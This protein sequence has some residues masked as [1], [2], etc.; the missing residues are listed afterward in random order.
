MDEMKAEILKYTKEQ[1]K[2]FKEVEIPWETVTLYH[3]TTSKHIN[4]IIK[5]GITPRTTNKQNNFAHVPS[6]EEL[7]YLTSKW[8]YWYAFNA[9]QNSLIEQVGE[10]RYL[11]EPIEDLW[12]E[13][14][15][16]PMYVEI[17][18]PVEVLTLDEDVVYQMDIRKGLMDGSITEVSQI[19]LDSCLQQGTAASLVSIPPEWISNFGIIG[20]QEFRDGLL[21][22]QYGADT[23]GWFSGFGM[24]ETDTLSIFVAETTNYNN[25][26]YLLPMEYPPENM[27]HVSAIYPSEEGLVVKIAS[28]EEII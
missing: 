13:T 18:V 24:G 3:G 19:T 28:E 14:M 22:G 10:E 1:K 25:K 16:Y 6:N 5:D 23:H 26:N 11:N 4:S 15:D 21:D 27:P 8:H 17:E 12:K 9:N 2:N 7:V 20:S